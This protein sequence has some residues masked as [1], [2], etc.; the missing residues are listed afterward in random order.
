MH[1]TLRIGVLVCDRETDELVAKY[2][3]YDDLFAR[4]FRLARPDLPVAITALDAEHGELPA[5]PGD[6]DALVITGSRWSAAADDLPWVVALRHFV[7]RVHAEQST[8]LIGI[9]FGSQLLAVALG[10]AVGDNP[11]GWEAGLTEI[12]LAPA[13]AAMTGR[14]TMWIQQA[15]GEAV[16]TVPPECAVLGASDRCAVQ[17]FYMPGR[18]LTSQCHPEFHAAFN[19]E[20]IAWM[21]EHAMG[22]HPVAFSPLRGEGDALWWGAQL[23][24]FAQHGTFSS[25]SWSHAPAVVKPIPT[26]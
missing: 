20:M 15:H 2:G 26:A 21:N 23:L 19:E 11:Q 25:E 6:F 17:G 22:D 12:T 1:P 13:V 10:G 14:R 5:T 7:Q 9:C 16:L 24:H 4:L 18:L 8:R 3:T